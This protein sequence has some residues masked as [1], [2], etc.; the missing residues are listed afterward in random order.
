MAR[1]KKTAK[2]HFLAGFEGLFADVQDEP[3]QTVRRRYLVA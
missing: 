3:Q 1:N 2:I